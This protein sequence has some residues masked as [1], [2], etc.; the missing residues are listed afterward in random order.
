MSSYFISDGISECE[1]SDDENRINFQEIREF[2]LLPSHLCEISSPVSCVG[3]YFKACPVLSLENQCKNWSHAQIDTI[4]RDPYVY[5]GF[6]DEQYC[7]FEPDT[8]TIE[9]QQSTGNHLLSCESYNCTDTHFK[10]PGFYCLPWRYVCDKNWDCPGGTDEQCCTR[11][12]EHTSCPGQLSCPGSIICVALTDVCNNVNDCPQSDDEMFCIPRIPDCISGCECLLFSISCTRKEPKSLTFIGTLPYIAV[13]I[14]HFQ[15]QMLHRIL[16]LLNQTIILLSRDNNIHDL[17]L[18]MKNI[19]FLKKNQFLYHMD[20]SQNKIKSLTS[21]CFDLENCIAHLNMSSN[22]ILSIGWQ[23]LH[24][25]HCLLTL[26]L[27]NNYISTLQQYSLSNLQS[28]QILNLT[29]NLFLNVYWLALVGSNNIKIISTNSYKICCIKPTI[30][31]SCTVT[32]LWPNSC[33]KLLGSAAIEI[34][35]WFI[36]CLGVLMN[37]PP[38]LCYGKLY[39][40]DIGKSYRITVACISFGDLLMS[41]S[42]LIIAVADKA[43]GN[44]YME[45]ESQ[46]RKHVICYSVAAISLSSNLISVFTLHVMALSRL[47][48][49]KYSMKTVFVKVKYV[50][51]ILTFGIAIGIVLGAV[52]VLSYRFFS[53]RAYTETGLCLLIGYKDQSLFSILNTT[54]MILTQ[55]TSALTIPGIYFSMFR[56]LSIHREKMKEMTTSVK[57]DGATRSFIA[58]MVNLTCWIPSCILLIMTLTWKNYPYRILVWTIVIVLPL[59]A[60]LD[61]VIFSYLGLLQKLLAQYVLANMLE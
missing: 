19:S 16:A 45:Y 38:L 33:R 44:R 60:L 34:V 12:I 4:K 51:Y 23:A 13:A 18:F 36:S 6:G 14:H 26:D 25:L 59:N 10:C 41:I 20:F 2:L 43:L 27:A 15:T 5:K 55:G 1:N 50:F 47:F 42:L 24:R 30:K 35:T 56:S 22:K 28:L 57:H 29:G 54:V 52:L 46:W 61:P 9:G 8:V 48:V 40:S 31:T 32:P 49:I 11:S 58:S 7:V 21:K 39:S 37:M 53:N 3:L 17:C